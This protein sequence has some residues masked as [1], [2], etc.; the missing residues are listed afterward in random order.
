MVKYNMYRTLLYIND[1]VYY[2]SQRSK[3]ELNSFRSALIVFNYWNIKF[4]VHRLK[5][6]E[7]AS[8]TW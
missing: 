7:W 3:K 6:L 8:R 2:N 1:L 4:I 5:S